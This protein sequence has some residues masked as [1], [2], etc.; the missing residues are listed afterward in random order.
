MRRPL[1]Y[2]CSTVHSRD[3]PSE[4]V[5]APVPGCDSGRDEGTG[6]TAM[7]KSD[8]FQGPGGFRTPSASEG[9]SPTPQQNPPTPSEKDT[10]QRWDSTDTWER[11]RK[12][13]SWHN[14]AQG[15]SKVRVEKGTKEIMSRWHSNQV[16]VG[17]EEGITGIFMQD[18]LNV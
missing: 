5:E 1:C 8:T 2:N 7:S 15:E 11:R 9:V 4:P 17:P 16:K 10:P 12:V 18:V 3:V 14:T 13:E 6:S